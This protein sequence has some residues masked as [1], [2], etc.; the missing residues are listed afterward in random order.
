M[1][2][3]QIVKCVG[4]NGWDSG[5]T[6]GEEYVI[7]A[8]KGDKR[9]TIAG[10]TTPIDDDERAVII[11]DDGDSITIIIPKCAFGEWEVVS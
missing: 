1:K 5:I 4:V 3:G 10:I 11:D 8:G 9:N 2:K 6:I 7:I